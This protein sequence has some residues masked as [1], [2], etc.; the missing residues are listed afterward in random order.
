MRFGLPSAEH[1]II[2]IKLIEL[3]QGYALDLG[4][5]RAKHEIISIKLIGRKQGYTW[6]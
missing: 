2:S 3:K 1:E 5:E 4:Y 6:D